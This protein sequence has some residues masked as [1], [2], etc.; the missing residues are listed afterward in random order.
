M[1]GRA[2]RRL[3]MVAVCLIS[4]AI[5]CYVLSADEGAAFWC[6]GGLLR[7]GSAGGQK[8]VDWEVCPEPPGSV[9]FYEHGDQ[10]RVHG[11]RS[12]GGKA[13]S[14]FTFIQADPLVNLCF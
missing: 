1:S 12:P 14:V 2:E 10:C 9:C 3:F 4:S 5:S 7:I 8:D 6:L 13:L 11:T